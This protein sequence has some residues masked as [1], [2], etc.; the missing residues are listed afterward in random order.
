ML[1]RKHL[2]T[3]FYCGARFW[4][5]SSSSV[6]GVLDVPS[7]TPPGPS[8]CVLEAAQNRSSSRRRRS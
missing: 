6:V 7:G 8:V 2:K 5:A 1:K 3:S 4:P